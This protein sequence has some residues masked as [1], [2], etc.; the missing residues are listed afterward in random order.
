[1]NQIIKFKLEIIIF[2]FF[3]ITRFLFIK[4][5][6]F[7]NFEL[8]LDS[9]WYSEQSNEVLKG[10]FNLARPL[11]IPAPFFSYFQALVKFIFFFFW[12][13]ALENLQILFSSIF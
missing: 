3:F 12:M 11:F 10:N 2:F 6:G 7:D 1:M 13:S 4:I 5:S 8:Q 9:Y